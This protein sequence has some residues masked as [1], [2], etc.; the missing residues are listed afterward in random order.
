[1]EPEPDGHPKILIIEDEPETADVFRQL[2][3]VQSS[4]EVEIA[5]SLDEARV[6]MRGS[7]FDLITLDYKLP[8]GLSLDFL[9]EITA[10]EKHPPVIMITGRGDENIASL[11]FQRGAVGYIVKNEELA[12]TLPEAVTKALHEYILVKAVEAVRESEAFYHTLFNEASDLLFIET[13]E[14]IIEDANRAACRML[15]YEVSEL[16]GKSALDLVPPARRSEFEE[17]VATLV[18]GARIVFENVR[19]DGSVVPV[20][21]TAKEVITRRGTRYIVVSRDIS[22]RISAKKALDDERAFTDDALDAIQD[23]FVVANISGS[24]YKWNRS[25]GEVTGYSDEEIRAM[26]SYEF[27]SSEDYMRLRTLIEDVARTDESRKLDAMIIN[28]DG[29]KIPYEMTGSL[30]RD[31]DGK[32]LGVAG[33]CRDIS[34]SKRA[35]DALR[36]VIKDTNERREEITALLESTRLVLEQKD[37][38]RAARDI[39]GLCW[40]LVGSD[41]GYLALLNEKNDASEIL[42][43]EPEALRTSFDSLSRMPVD[44]FITP[45][46]R[47]GKAFY[48]NDFPNSDW[49]RRMPGEPF[50]VESVLIAPLL[51]DGEPAGMIGFA[52]KPG[53]FTGRDALMASAFGEVA[54]V[55]LRDSRT[56]EKLQD[57]EE[58]FR[59]VAETAMEAII[60]ADSDALITFWNASAEHIF[61]YRADEM[62]GKPLTAILPERLREARMPSMLREATED[63]TP[64]RIFEMAGLRADGT[65]FPMELSRSTWKV[66]GQINFTVIIRDITDRKRAEDVLRESEELY[67]TLLY[68]S[69]DA[70]TVFDL[71]GNVIDCSRA[72]ADLYGCEDQSE[73]ISINGR[74]LVPPEEWEKVVMTVG[75]V[76]EDGAVRNVE[77]TIRRKDGTLIIGEVNSAV[78]KDRNGN[79]RG[80][81]DVIRDVTERNK[82]E[83]ELQVLNNELEGYAHVVSHDLKGPLSS[84]MA[85]ALALRGL[86]KGEWNEQ[87]TRSAQELVGIIESNV[88]KSAALIDDLLDLAEA[89][90]NPW[91]V[92]DV[93]IA[94]V[95]ERVLG[96]RAEEIKRRKFKIKLD[97]NLG[98]VIANPTHMYQL[99]SNLVQNSISH[100]DNRKPEVHVSY[101]GRNEVGLHCYSVYDNGSGIDPAAIDKIFLPFYATAEGNTGIGLATVEKI[102][103]VYSG[104][105]RTFND[106]GA[107][108]EFTLQDYVTPA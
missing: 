104:T 60:C 44:Q 55:A 14:G 71:E 64:S 40:K 6:R 33:T 2:L 90:Q 11:A 39:F 103:H 9:S 89:G 31:R 68:A 57:S 80:Y 37:F 95:I 83:H 88:K 16:R 108:F 4:A 24:F 59:S 50:K 19:K 1:M 99:F 76:L 75:K 62:M 63:K 46:F 17:A 45:A 28:K 3:E 86:S 65:E 84:M 41:S 81:I 107:R 51:V 38:D 66:G 47:S 102:V 67:R 92:S 96:E 105:I 34:E 43:V 18:E 23:I 94:P 48:H 58:R 26:R 32:P 7:T 53:G 52:N 22:E 42:F 35:E 87:A 61:G 101:K 91:E 12:T 10:S 8:D 20:E 74:E 82:A 69:P 49:A 70:V 15:G 27:L 21:M 106:N 78:L 25:L 73:I 5:N 100:N 29:R 77:L 13:P 54:S 36:N 97:A 79:P 93:D 30:I 56:L 85:A 98:H 72:T